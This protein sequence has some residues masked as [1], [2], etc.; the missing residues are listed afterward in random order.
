VNTT[1]LNKLKTAH[2]DL[3]KL[4]MAVDEIYPIQCICGHRTN[5]DQQKALE[6]GNSKL[7]PG[8]SKHNRL[9]SLAIDCVPD[10][11]RNPKTIS[12]ADLKE[13]E[14]MCLT[15]ESKAEELGIKIRLGRD[16][17]IKDFPHIELVA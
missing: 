16:F 10:P 5:E 6:A 1:S 8:K 9:P 14:I 4:A 7:P 2:P 15:F 13:F 3:V 11:D 17:R 12:W